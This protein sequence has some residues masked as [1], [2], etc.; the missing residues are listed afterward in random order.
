MRRER[1][2]VGPDDPPVLADELDDGSRPARVVV[3]ERALVGTGQG[4]RRLRAQC[5]VDRAPE[6][7]LDA[8]VDEGAERDE[9]QRHRGGEG[10]REPPADR[11]RPQHAPGSRNR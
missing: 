3:D 2:R 4:L 8:E 7:I 10:G 5:L 1:R 6:R 9:Q 11:D